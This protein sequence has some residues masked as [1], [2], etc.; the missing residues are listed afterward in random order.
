MPSHRHVGCS[1]AFAG[2]FH[3]EAP[4][5]R[6]FREGVS[7][8]RASGCEAVQLDAMATGMR[9]KDLDRSGRRE[10]AAILKREGLSLSGIDLWIPSEHYA[11]KARMDRALEAFR[12]ACGLAAEVARLVEAPS[13]TVSVTLP[14]KTTV[15]LVDAVVRPAMAT[16]V[17]IADFNR[18]EDRIAGILGEG[19]DPGGIILA[20][21]D[22]NMSV[23]ASTRG[24]IDARLTD[25]TRHS[26]CIVGRG[27]LD[28]TAYRA[29]LESLGMV[30]WVTVDVRSMIDPVR[31]ARE[32]VE[33]WR[34]IPR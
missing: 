28:V 24:M 7:L 25:A 23:V 15:E 22:A 27:E 33:A 18:Y 26:R 10:L 17:Q 31:A 5:A 29:T 34:T 11:D 4:P 19:F 1:L 2:L 16:G 3:G 32:A 8:A 21:G 9:A 6:R 12:E 14:P 30:R 13:P 20:G